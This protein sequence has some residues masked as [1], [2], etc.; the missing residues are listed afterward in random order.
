MALQ[1][2]IGGKIAQELPD[3]VTLLELSVLYY[4]DLY[5]NQDFLL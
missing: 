5:F 3:I 2:L 4:Y 1:A